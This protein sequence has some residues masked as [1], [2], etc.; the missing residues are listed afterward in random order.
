MN[1]QHGFSLIELMIALGIM[2]AALMGYMKM[3]AH[4][5]KQNRTN[6]AAQELS[7]YYR[8][9]SAYIGKGQICEKTFIDKA[10]VNNLKINSIKKRNG[11]DKYLVGAPYAGNV[12]KIKSMNLTEVEKEHDNIFKGSAQLTIHFEKMGKVYGVKE[13]RKTIEL[14]FIVNEKNKIITCASLGSLSLNSLNLAGLGLIPEVKED[15]EDVKIKKETIKVVKQIL[16][17]VEVAAKK[18][19]VS[20]TMTADKKK[21]E[22]LQAHNEKLLKTIQGLTQDAPAV[23]AADAKKIQAIIDA[24]PQLKEVQNMIKKMQLQHKKML[25]QNDY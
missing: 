1:K 19:I 2:T 9:I 10:L 4:Q 17:K 24:N 12:V 6:V 23:P 25:E 13:I 11:T 5:T 7:N 18:A 20:K 8:E 22:E 15:K 16:P 21:M 14:D 3:M